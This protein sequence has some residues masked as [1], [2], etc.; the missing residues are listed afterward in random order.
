MGNS[1]AS[2]NQS[3]LGQCN[4]AT[5][6]APRPCQCPFNSSF[7]T[8]STDFFYAGL[9]LTL[10][11]LTC[12]PASHSWLCHRTSCLARS[13]NGLLSVI[14]PADNSITLAR[15]RGSHGSREAAGVCTNCSS[16]STPVG[17]TARNLLLS[18]ATANK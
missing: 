8:C 10:H 6:I 11:I 2:S 4:L 9:Q 12:T 18:P 3:T 13:S 16:R 7:G 14:H 15:F 5:C 1:K 17:N